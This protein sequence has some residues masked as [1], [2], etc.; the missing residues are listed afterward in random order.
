MFS[1][2]EHRALIFYTG[3]SFEDSL[4]PRSFSEEVLRGRGLDLRL[5]LGVWFRLEEASSFDRS[6]IT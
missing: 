3:C 5:M 2:R 1:S 6:S 4:E